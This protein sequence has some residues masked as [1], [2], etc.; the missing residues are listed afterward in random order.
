MIRVIELCIYDGCNSRCIMCPRKYIYQSRTSMTFNNIE[1]ICRQIK[2]A[3]REKQIIPDPIIIIGLFGEPLLDKYLSRKISVIKRS[4]PDSKIHVYTNGILLN[5]IKESDIKDV[6]EF[7]ISKYGKTKEEFEKITGLKTDQELYNTYS[8]HIE[9]F[10]KYKNV[11]VWDALKEG[12]M[13]HFST[14]AGLVGSFELKESVKGCRWKRAEQ[15]IHILTNGDLILCCQ[16][17]K[18]ETVY[19]NIYENNLHNILKGRRRKDIVDKV[20]GDRES[21]LLF[22]CKRCRKAMIDS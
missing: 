7:I 14:R 11:R 16:D 10:K 1:R 22:I 8:S 2:E 9:R 18:S 5:R 15:Y 13:D 12:K 20:N 19:G 4:I 3:I 17:W 6:E 21:D